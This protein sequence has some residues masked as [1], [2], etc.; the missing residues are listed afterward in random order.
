MREIWNWNLPISRWSPLNKEKKEEEE[1]GDIKETEE[2]TKK[3][4]FCS[5]LNSLLS[6][7]E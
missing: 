3:T 4:L 6:M 1:R 5:V 7:L 2:V